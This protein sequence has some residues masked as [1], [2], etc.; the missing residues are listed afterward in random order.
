MH[1]NTKT[2]QTIQSNG[3]A[4]GGGRVSAGQQVDFIY[5]GGGRVSAGQQVDYINFIKE[6]VESV[7][8][9]R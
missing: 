3:Q 9:N 6:E 2:I 4:E 8:D 5:Q 7:L 1:F